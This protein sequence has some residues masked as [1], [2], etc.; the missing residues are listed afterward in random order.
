MKVRLHSPQ[1]FYLLWGGGLES[2]QLLFS[3]R[4]DELFRGAWVA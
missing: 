1:C 4:Q 3:T 2:F